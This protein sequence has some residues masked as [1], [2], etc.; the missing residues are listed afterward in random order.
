MAKQVRVE[1][2][3]CCVYSER[4]DVEYGSW[5]ERYE[6][7]IEAVH[8]ISEDDRASRSSDIFAVPDDANEVYV[9]YMIYDTGDSFGRSDGHID[10]IHCTANEESA[11]E[12][13]K[14]I[15]ENSEEFTIKYVDDFG[16]E[17][18]IRNNAA[19]YFEHIQYVEV[20]RF[21]IGNSPRKSRYYVN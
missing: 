2:N 20:K 12:L 13:A 14:K 16:R 21:S 8:V 3:E 11:H 5:E 1:Y 10:V 7:S 17:I 19:G 18:S 6:S 9:V 15:T 4:E